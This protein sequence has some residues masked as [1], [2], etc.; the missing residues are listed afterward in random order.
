MVL[1]G[2]LSIH[3][4]PVGYEVDRVCGPII[5]SDGDHVVLFRHEEQTEKGEKCMQLVTERLSDNEIDHEIQE[6]HFFELYKYLGDIREQIDQHEGEDIFVNIS[7][8]SKITAVAGMMACMAT[9]TQPYY[10]RAQEYKGEVITEE[11]GETIP[12]S[13][14][15]VGLPDKQYL[16]VLEFLC[17]DE[18]VY[19]KDIIEY[20]DDEDLPLLSGY[21]RNQ[22]KNDYKPVNEEIIEPL[23][24]RGFIEIHRYKQGK[25]VEL[26]EDGQKTLEGLRY[27]LD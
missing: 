6:T 23:E 4:A 25:K 3:L 16:K 22:L 20:V 10:V 8:G 18:T 21:S 1:Q 15:P 19:K 24:K 27:L 9:G 7:T 17:T 5:E 12:L 26:T 14:Y 2:T 13:A 11:R